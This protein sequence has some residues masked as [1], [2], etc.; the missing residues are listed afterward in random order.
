MIKKSYAESKIGQKRGFDVIFQA[1]SSILWFQTCLNTLLTIFRPVENPIN[2][3][4]SETPH[5]SNKKTY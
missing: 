5:F 4:N 2:R 1:K 3:V